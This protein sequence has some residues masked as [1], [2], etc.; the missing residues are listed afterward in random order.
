MSFRV[1]AF[2]TETTGKVDFQADYKAPKQP[3]L[4]QLGFKLISM[5]NDG[6][7]ETL[8]EVGVL[9]DTSNLDPKRMWAIEPEAQNVHGISAEMVH[10]FGIN[11]ARAMDSFCKWMGHSDVIIAHNI[12]FDI[13]IMQTFAYRSQYSPGLFE[14]RPRYCTM[15]NSTNICKIPHPRGY[16]FKWPSLKEAYGML[17]KPEGF[18]NAHNALA[19]VNACIEVFSYHVRNGLYVAGK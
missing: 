18:G 1:F 8:Y 3:D 7:Y 9:V 12:Q 15:T 6:K 17:V 5:E 14:D 4:I 10:D 19:D 13:R 11:P 16:G 2:D